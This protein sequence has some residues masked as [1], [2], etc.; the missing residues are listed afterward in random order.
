[1]RGTISLPSLNLSKVIVKARAILNTYAHW[2]FNNWS[3]S[4]IANLSIKNNLKMETTATI[5]FNSTATYAF[6]YMGS[7][8]SS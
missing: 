4:D 8:Q 5:Q 2:R 6:A 1:M 7:F 3:L